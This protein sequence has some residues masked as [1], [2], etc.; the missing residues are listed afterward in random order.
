MSTIPRTQGLD[1]HGS[2]TP[3]RGTPATREDLMLALAAGAL[4][5]FLWAIRSVVMLVAFALLLAWC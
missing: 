1:Y 5:V 3:H 2:M 4:L